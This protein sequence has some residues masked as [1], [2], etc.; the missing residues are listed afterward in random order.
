MKHKGY[1][2][3][4]SLIFISILLVLTTSIIK[5]GTNR[6]SSLKNLEDQAQAEYI[7]ESIINIIFGENIDELEKFYENNYGSLSSPL[8]LPF[9][10]SNYYDAQISAT[11]QSDPAFKYNK[12]LIRISSKYKNITSRCVAS[13]TTINEIYLNKEGIALDNSENLNIFKFY[14]PKE[15][16]KI[17][18]QNDSEIYLDKNEIVIKDVTTNEIVARIPNYKFVAIIND[19][20]L[21]FRDSI[22]IKGMFI[23]N[24]EIENEFDFNLKGIFIDFS[25]KSQNIIV[26]G[27]AAYYVRPKKLIYDYDFLKEIRDELPKFFKFKLEKITTSDLVN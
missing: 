9:N 13:G 25:K 17:R 22:N 18:I 19:E 12:F 11:I 5:I 27:T 26:R 4:I 6:V 8:E 10:F 24:G 1:V 20:K 3:V 7:P 21:I 14:E 16:T 15:L 23:N 2:L